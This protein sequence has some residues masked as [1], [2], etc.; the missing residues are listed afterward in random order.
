MHRVIALFVL[1]ALGTLLVWGSDLHIYYNAKTHPC[2]KYWERPA[3]DDLVHATKLVCSQEGGRKK[4]FAEVYQLTDGSWYAY[5][6]SD[7]DL[8][9]WILH[10]REASGEFYDEA[11]AK[12]AM[13]KIQ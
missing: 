10:Q 7:Y 12:R 6:R 2:E 8:I 5:T 3:P 1:I 4:V 9:S 11:S 13:E